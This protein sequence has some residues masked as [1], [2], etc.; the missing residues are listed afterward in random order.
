[1]A[2]FYRKS[3]CSRLRRIAIKHCAAD[4]LLIYRLTEEVS[5][6][7]EDLPSGQNTFS[8]TVTKIFCQGQERESVYLYDVTR[9]PEE[10][11]TMFNTVSR[12]LITPCCAEEIVSDLISYYAY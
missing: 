3:K 7:T 4:I 5:K 11:N 9:D 1:M 6:K 12:A 8:L 2:R 10:A